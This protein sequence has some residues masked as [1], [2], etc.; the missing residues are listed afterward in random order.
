MVELRR[1]SEM[2]GVSARIV[3]KLE[4]Q[5]PCGS[6]KDRAGLYMIRDAEKTGRLRPGGVIIEPTS[7]NTGIALAACAAVLGYRTIIV[8][9]DSMSQERI[10][11]MGAYGAEVVLTPGAEGMTGAIK[12]AE[13]LCAATP[14]SIIAGQFDNPANPQ[15][16][17]ETTGPEI[18]ADCDGKVDILVA[19]VG[20]GGTI[21]GAGK[22]LK[23]KDP[24]VQVVAVEPRESPVIS[25]GKAGAHGIQ[26]IGGGFIP[27][28]LDTS[29]YDEVLCVSTDAAYDAMRALARTEGL[30]CGISSGAAAAA[31]VELAKR[32]ENTGKTIVAV[33]TDTGERYL[34]VF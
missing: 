29:V 7:G 33:L 24:S 27:G 3:A 17:Y 9:P 16:H 23:E 32:P 34:S 4:R 13:E 6:A 12:K 18:W 25:G 20:T 8:M 30:L 2:Q 21:S 22:Y 28:A 31:A 10:K 1:Y 11:L 26:G 15:A 5:N 14:G 19:G